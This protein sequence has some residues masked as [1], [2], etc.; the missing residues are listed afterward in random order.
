[1][2][3]ITWRSPILV[4]GLA[5]VGIETFGSV[6]YLLERDGGV[7]YLVLAGAACTVLSGFLPW[8]GERA[9]VDGQRLAGLA[10][11]LLLPLTL[12]TIFFA[13]IERSGSA[14]DQANKAIAE[15]AMRIELAHAA[16]ADA[17]A[18]LADASSVAAAECGSGRGRRCQSLE[19]RERDA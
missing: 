6:A 12:S 16:I 4:A 2:L 9:W 5:L 7:S 10:A 3:E 8:I 1:M 18:A 11:F 13:A 19:I 14:M 17:K 15:Q